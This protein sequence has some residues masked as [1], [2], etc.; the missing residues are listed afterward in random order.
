MLVTETNESCQFNISIVLRVKSVST[1][2]R[3]SNSN[4]SGG[5][6]KTR[7][8]TWGPHYDADETMAVPEPHWKQF[9]HLISCERYR[10]L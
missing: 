9:L 1:Y 2:T 7:E 4:F 3:V 8:V 5:Q 10:A 6:M